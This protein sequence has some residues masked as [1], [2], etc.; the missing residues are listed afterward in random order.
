VSLRWR[1]RG[2]LLCGAN[3]KPKKDDTYIDDRLHYHL[4]QRLRI[5]KPTKGNKWVWRGLD[6]GG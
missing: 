3:S 2:L 1:K 4:S 6:E 5:I